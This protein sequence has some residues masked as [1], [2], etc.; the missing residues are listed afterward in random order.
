MY[1]FTLKFDNLLNRKLLKFQ[2]C[3]NYYYDPIRKPQFP[4]LN[5]YNTFSTHSLV[6][7]APG[8][9]TPVIGMNHIIAVYL[10]EIGMY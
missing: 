2:K 9:L 7:Q 3:N 5:P 4:Y 1:V 8:S 6:E 10:A